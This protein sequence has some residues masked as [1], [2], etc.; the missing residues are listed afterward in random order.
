MKECRT[1]D[2][3]AEFNHG[4]NV[5]SLCDVN[6]PFESMKIKKIESDNL[7]RAITAEELLIGIE[8]DIRKIYRKQH[9][10]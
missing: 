1:I 3:L 9:S 10:I 8:E 6:N 4:D 7:E 2:S 5:R